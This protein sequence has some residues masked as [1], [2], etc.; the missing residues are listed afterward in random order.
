MR[1]RY[2]DYA[3]TYVSLGDGKIRLAPQL[4]VEANSRIV[5]QRVCDLVVAAFCVIDGSAVFYSDGLLA[6]PHDSSDLEDLDERD[7]RRSDT[8]AR[9]GAMLASRLAAKCSQ[10]KSL[11]YALF[12]LNL[13]FQSASTHWIDLDPSH[14]PNNFKVVKDPKVHVALANAITLAYSAI[15]E[16]QLEPRPKG[17]N[18]KVKNQDGTWDPAALADL[19]A[20]LAGARIDP[21]EQLVWTERG[22]K[23]RIHKSPRAPEGAKASWS[24][25]IVRDKSVSVQD[26]LVAASWLRSRCTTHRFRRETESITMFDVNNVQRLAGRLITETVG[27]RR[28]G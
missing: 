7:L 25:G 23:T 4:F 20:R 8:V 11:A 22:S 26:A 17:D 27:L 9:Y 2:P 15:E 28:P 10:R 18:N 13:S 19:N 24:R 5:A 6:L 16:L 21:Q 3:E 12:K 14:G 1:E